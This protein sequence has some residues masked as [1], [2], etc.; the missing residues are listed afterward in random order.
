MPLADNTLPHHESVAI[1]PFA[2]WASAQ[3]SPNYSFQLLTTSTPPPHVNTEREHRVFKK[4]ELLHAFVTRFCGRKTLTATEVGTVIRSVRTT[5]SGIIPQL[6]TVGS[7]SARLNH[8]ATLAAHSAVTD[9]RG[10]S[11]HSLVA[12]CC[13]GRTVVLNNSAWQPRQ[14]LSQRHPGQ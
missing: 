2:S 11:Y 6:L 4:V 10:N 7:G 13:L 9:G 3:S 12:R 5:T 1:V 8:A 14:T